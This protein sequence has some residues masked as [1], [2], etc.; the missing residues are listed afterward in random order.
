VKTKLFNYL[1]GSA[2]S[3]TQEINIDSIKSFYDAKNEYKNM[4]SDEESELVYGENLKEDECD[5]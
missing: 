1:F 4:F 2:D 5:Y 3:V